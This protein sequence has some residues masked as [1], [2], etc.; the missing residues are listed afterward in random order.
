MCISHKREIQ[1][2]KIKKPK[3][4]VYISTLTEKNANEG[5]F[6]ESL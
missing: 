5:N 6:V 2:V 4:N 1:I 3:A